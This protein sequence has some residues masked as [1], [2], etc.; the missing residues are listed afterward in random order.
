MLDEVNTMNQQP[1]IDM[2]KVKNLMAREGYTTETLA[3]E[4]QISPNTLSKYLDGTKDHSRM[5]CGVFYRM[6]V[7]LHT[8]CAE[9]L[10]EAFYDCPPNKKE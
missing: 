1:L 9:I 6:V 2:Q 8:T 3:K 5:R 7:A 10:T 4:M